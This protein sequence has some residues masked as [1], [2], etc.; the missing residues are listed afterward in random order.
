[1]RRGAEFVLK[2]PQGPA[3]PLS[4][5]E[6]EAAGWILARPEVTE[7]ELRAAHPAVD[8]AGLLARLR[9]AGLLALSAA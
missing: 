9:A 8:A 3:L 1:V 7:G 5:A 2:V 6:A 4:A